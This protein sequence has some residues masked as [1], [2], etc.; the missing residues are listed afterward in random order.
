MMV[1]VIFVHAGSADYKYMYVPAAYDPDIL[2]A[3]M[4]QYIL[5]TSIRT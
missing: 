1:L 5:L 4:Y 3:C 2:Y